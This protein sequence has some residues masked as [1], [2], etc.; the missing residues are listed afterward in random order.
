MKDTIQV[1][2]NNLFQDEE[3][4]IIELLMDTETEHLH[5]KVSYKKIERHIKYMNE[6]FSYSLF[7]DYISLYMFISFEKHYR[8]CTGDK[9]KRLIC[10]YKGFE[11]LDNGNHCLN[12][13]MK[14]KHFNT[15][16]KIARS[17]KPECTEDEVFLVVA[18]NFKHNGDTILN[19]V[20]ND[21]NE[22]L[23]SRV[24]IEFLGCSANDYDEKLK[25]I[26][27]YYQKC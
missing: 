3:H 5:G 1:R 26:Y 12:V 6:M 13:S 2:F 18:Q 25:E 27:G 24:I 11:N 15:W 4:N 16:L 17:I 7:Y 14:D 23:Y 22:L 8:A 10:S 20:C 21:L 9:R 19:H